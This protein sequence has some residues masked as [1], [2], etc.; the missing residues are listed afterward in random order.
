VDSES[1]G[2][3]IGEYQTMYLWKRLGQE[4]AGQTSFCQ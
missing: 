2:K 1:L 4:I 3:Q